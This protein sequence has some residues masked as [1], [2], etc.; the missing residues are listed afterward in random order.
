MSAPPPAAPR[1]RANSPAAAC[2][3]TTLEAEGRFGRGRHL[4]APNA[5]PLGDYAFVSGRGAVPIVEEGQIV[6]AVGVS[7]AAPADHDHTIADEA[8]GHPELPKS[9]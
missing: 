9:H 2:R 1:A 4:S 7:G 5:A 3:T 6:G 8:A